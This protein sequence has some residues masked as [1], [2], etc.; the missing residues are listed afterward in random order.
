MTGQQNPW[1]NSFSIA[2][3]LATALIEM[4]RC[5]SSFNKVMFYLK[6]KIIHTAEQII[7]IVSLSIY[8]HL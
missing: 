5:L 4:T 7:P 2:I 8:F 6:W 1:Q 3:K